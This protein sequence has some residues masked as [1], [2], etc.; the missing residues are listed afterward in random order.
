MGNPYEPEL[1]RDLYVMLGTSSAALIGLL[2]IVTSLHLSE[3]A[4]NP[5]L[6]RRANHRTIYLLILLIEAVLI[7]LPQPMFVLGWE[8]V[9]INLFGMI[10]PLDNIYRFY[11]V[12]GKDAGERDDWAIMR[13]I[14][15]ST[16]LLIGVAGGATLARLAWWGM[17]MVTASYVALLVL[18]ALNAWSIMFMIGQTGKPK[19]A[20][21]DAAR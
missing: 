11:L 10:F 18:V 21:R 19:A 12:G 6:R 3:I 5:V 2:F 16:T 14:R 13:A 4:N 7:L 15:Y 8:L 17:Y 9:V 1:W 20:E